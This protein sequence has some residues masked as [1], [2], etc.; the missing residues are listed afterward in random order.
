ML[1]DSH[2]HL[3]KLDLT[4]YPRGLD[5]V[6]EE[7]RALGVERFISVGVDLEGHAALL[8]LTEPYDFVWISVGVHPNDTQVV[9]SVDKLCFLAQHS[10]VVAVGETGL[11]Y[12]RTVEKEQQQ[13]SF[14]HHIRAAIALKKPLI[15]HTREAAED[16]LTLLEEEGA[17]RCGGVFHCFTESAE[18]AYRAIELGFYISFSGI[19]T[20]KNSQ[21]LQA[22]AAQIPLDRLLVETDSPWLAPVPFRGKPNYPGYT[23]LVAEFIADLR[24]ISIEQLAQQ[25]TKN[26]EVLFLLEAEHLSFLFPDQ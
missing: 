9:P 23:R 8:A 22:V 3:D 7:A 18:I 4:L 20:F 25:S 19:V 6:F 1:I 21:A 5:Q 13:T 11:D 17:Q 12:Y 24:K 15:I 16:T 2:C 26:T 14:R 10:K